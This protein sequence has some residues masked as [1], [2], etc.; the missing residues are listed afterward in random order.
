MKITKMLF[1]CIAAILVTLALVSCKSGGGQITLPGAPDDGSPII[2][3]PTPDDIDG[4]GIVNASDNCPE[5]PNPDQEDADGDGIGDACDEEL[6]PPPSSG[7]QDGDG[8]LDAADNCPT[9]ANS[10]QADMDG[11]GQGNV[12]DDDRDGDGINNSSDNCPDD[13]NPNQTDTDN[14][15]I[16]DVC[17]ANTDSDGDGVDDG[18]DNCP[19]IANSNQADNDSD[20][21]GDV[22]D[23]DDDNDGVVDGS[24]NCPADANANQADTDHDGLGDVCDTYTVMTVSMV[25]PNNAKLALAEKPETNDDI[26]RVHRYSRIEIAYQGDR[27]TDQ[28]Q[29]TQGGNTVSASIEPDASG[30]LIFKPDQPLHNM[31]TYEIVCGGRTFQFTVKVPGDINADGKSEVVIGSPAEPSSTIAGRVVISYDNNSRS[32]ITHSVPSSG[33]DFGSAVAVGDVNGD[34]ID[35]VV[36]GLPG[37]ARGHVY[38]FNGPINEGQSLTENDA[39][40]DLWRFGGPL[41]RFGAALALGDY[42]GDGF[43]ELAVGEPDA[44]DYNNQSNSSKKEGVVHLFYGGSNGIASRSIDYSQN[45]TAELAFRLSTASTGQQVGFSLAFMDVNGDT[46]EDI[47]I[48]APGHD[49]DTTAGIS[50][51]VPGRVYVQY[52]S[53]AQY[54]PGTRLLLNNLPAGQKYEGQSTFL[55]PICNSVRTNGF[56]RSVAV[57]TGGT[58]YIGT[59]RSKAYVISNGVM[60]DLELAANNIVDPAAKHDVVVAVIKSGV[61]IGVPDA[62]TFAYK[63]RAAQNWVVVTRTTNTRLGSAI[64]PI[65]DHDGDGS[66]DYAVSEELFTSQMIYGRV[67]IDLTGQGAEKKIKNETLWIRKFGHAIAPAPM[68]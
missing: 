36:V 12:C 15:G 44:S 53:D 21:I 37:L 39:D 60:T 62:N 63:A 10:D 30:V 47:I 49:Q 52:G 5:V 16:G 1:V 64:A 24:D 55:D 45:R 66:V 33:R 4:D 41:S 9:I 25:L 50:N 48:G 42:N 61:G 46:L 65:G 27:G 40:T 17:D 35:D 59:G 56:G 11:D 67:L 20:G 8:V 31:Q 43:D 38:I 28:P 22:C 54:G 19:E 26:H 57:S 23:D 3:K 6:G 58:L 13:A 7:D 18:V 51:C 32:T 34:G 29:L 2:V 68:K 14:D